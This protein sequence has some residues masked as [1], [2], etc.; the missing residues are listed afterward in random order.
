MIGA[1]PQALYLIEVMLHKH[2]LCLTT[3]EQG[4]CAAD[5]LRVVRGSAGAL[6]SLGQQVPILPEGLALPNFGAVLQWAAAALDAHF[7]ALSGR[8]EAFPTAAKLQRAVQVW[9][10]DTAGG[11]CYSVDC[12]DVLGALYGAP[13]DASSSSSSALAAGVI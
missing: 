9:L 7:P 1:C 10:R 8:P 5:M 2:D 12:L 6:A 13:D 3:M 4:V 11:A